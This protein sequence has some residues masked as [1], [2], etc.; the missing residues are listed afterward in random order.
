MR[1]APLSSASRA[2]YIGHA[3]VVCVKIA[4]GVARD[5]KISGLEESSRC[6]FFAAIFEVVYIA[7]ILR[8]RYDGW[9][10]AA[11]RAVVDFCGGG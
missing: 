5:G 9:R 10:F 1:R 2:I 3:R 11:P 7:R 6:K 8:L 4:N